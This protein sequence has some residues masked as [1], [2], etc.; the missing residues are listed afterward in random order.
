ML[1]KVHLTSHSR[2]SGSRCGQE[3]FRRN[4]LTLIVNKRVQNAV[5]GCNLKNDRM[6]IPSWLCGSWRSFLHSS[7]LCSC[8]LFLISSAS[9]RSIQFLSFI[10]PITAWNIPLVSLTFLKSSLVFPIPFFPSISLHWSL[11]KAFLLLLAILWNSTFKW[12]HFSSSP[13]PLASLLFS[14]TC[15]T[16][17]DNHFSFLQFFFLGMVLIPVSYTMLWTSIHSSSHHYQI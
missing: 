11:R 7:S 15:K 5:L 17:S 4:G 9:V 16:S 6:I 10:E 2:M 1:P 3:S 12:V 13:L 8:H 14:A